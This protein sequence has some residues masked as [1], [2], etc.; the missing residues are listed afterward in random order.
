MLEWHDLNARHAAS[1]LW[2]TVTII[3]VVRSADGR[4]SVYKLL[5][6]LLATL[7]KPAISLL[8]VG[9]LA[10][11]A[12]LTSIAV[13]VGR[14]AGMWETLPVVTTIVWAFTTGFSLLFQLGDFIEGDNTFLSRAVALLGPSTIVAE[15]MGVAILPFWWELILVPILVFL[16]IALNL[17]RSTALRNVSTVLLSAYAVG[18]TSKVIIDLVADLGTLQ[19]LGQAIILP[20]V[21]TVGTLPYI[22]LIVVVERF[23]FSMT[24]K[25]KRVRS[26]EY[27][28]DWPLT[29]ASAE[30]CYKSQAVWVEVNGRKYGVNGFAGPILKSYG[31]A[32]FDLDEILRNHPDSEV[33]G[34]KVSIHRLNQDGLALE[35]Q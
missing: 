29:V 10:N 4:R 7:L 27:G 13:I 33:M 32:C 15:I 19:S 16:A 25:C 24:A 26:N 23:R 5:K 2:V 11:V 20:L 30:L 14:K 18:L 8:M 17:N 3:F 22:Q 21:L 1:F 12:F 34:Q 6:T 35:S 28:K 9:L 31:Y